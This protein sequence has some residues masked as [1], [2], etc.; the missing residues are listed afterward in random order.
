MLKNM[1]RVSPPR[2][3]C[4]YRCLSGYQ[5]LLFRRGQVVSLIPAAVWWSGYAGKIRK[6]EEMQNLGAA[7]WHF[8][9]AKPEC[10]IVEFLEVSLLTQFT[11]SPVLSLFEPFFETKT[12]LCPSH[13]AES[14]PN[15]S[16]ARCV[17]HCVR[18][19][20]APTF[21]NLCVLFFQ[22]PLYPDM[23]RCQGPQGSKTFKSLK[24]QSNEP[25]QRNQPLKAFSIK[26]AQVFLLREN[27]IE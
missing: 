8:H 16:L 3:F 25:N 24:A 5:L 4:D 26:A 14:Q 21:R 6:S 19:C 12:R 9:S 11:G 22:S 23:C 17:W 10:G 13:H 1:V 2:D 15:T 27:D 20:L 18:P 7:V